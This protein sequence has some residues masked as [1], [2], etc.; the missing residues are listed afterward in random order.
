MIEA[1][2]ISYHLNNKDVCQGQEQCDN[3]TNSTWDCRKGNDETETRCY[4]YCETWQVVLVDILAD[5]ALH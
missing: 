4:D 3:K 2:H 5:L 1:C